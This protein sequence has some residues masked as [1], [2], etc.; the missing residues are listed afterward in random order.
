MQLRLNLAE[1]P[2]PAAVL[3]ELVGEEERQTAMALLAALIARSVVGQSAGDEHD[4]V[5]S[6][7]E[8]NG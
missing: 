1:G 6:D 4:A 5:M 3:W 2:A 7:D 8:R